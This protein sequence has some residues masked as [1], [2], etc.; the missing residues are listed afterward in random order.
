MQGKRK[1]NCNFNVHNLFGNLSTIISVRVL[2]EFIT[3]H[4]IVCVAVSGNSL[5]FNGNR[6]A[7]FVFIKI[8]ALF[9]AIKEKNTDSANVYYIKG[10]NQLQIGDCLLNA[11][12]VFPLSQTRYG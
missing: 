3:H 9:I 11:P 4:I 1:R 8:N 10:A 6:Y 5:P 2:C 12:R 7:A